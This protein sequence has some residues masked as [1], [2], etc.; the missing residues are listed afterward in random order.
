MRSHSVGQPSGLLRSYSVGQRH[1]RFDYGA[2]LHN[3]LVSSGLLR[4]HSVG[5]RHKC[6]NYG[7]DLQND[8]V[9]SGLL[10]ISLWASLLERLS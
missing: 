10:R 5:Q 4:S 8:L 7:A 1:K 3:D 9:S 6:T 2:D